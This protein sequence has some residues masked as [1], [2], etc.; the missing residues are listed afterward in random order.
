MI[1]EPWTRCA[2]ANHFGVQTRPIVY[3]W[4]TS[5]DG[6]LSHHEKGIEPYKYELNLFGIRI[7]RHKKVSVTVRHG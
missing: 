3:F 6:Q 2:T 5:A 7:N 1:E 4:S